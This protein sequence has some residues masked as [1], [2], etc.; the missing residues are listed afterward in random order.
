VTTYARSKYGR[1]WHV[2]DAFQTYPHIRKT[3]CGLSFERVERVSEEMPTDDP[4][5]QICRLCRPWIGGKSQYA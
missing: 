5:E 4:V 2:A 3:L 1:K